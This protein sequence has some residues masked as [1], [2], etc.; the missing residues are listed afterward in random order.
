MEISFEG[1]LGVVVE[2]KY[3]K[4]L[5]DEEIVGLLGE[6]IGRYGEYKVNVVREEDKCVNL[7]VEFIEDIFRPDREE[8]FLTDYFCEVYC[9]EEYEWFRLPGEYLRDYRV[10]MLDRFGDEYSRDFLLDVYC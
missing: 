2:D 4:R 7:S 3:L 9:Y 1:W 8:I 10:G 5:T 6:Y